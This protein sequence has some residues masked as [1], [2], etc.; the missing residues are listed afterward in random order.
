M[1][2]RTLNYKDNQIQ[3]LNL[4]E[5]K[6]TVKEEGYDGKPVMGMYHFDFIER[7]MEAVDKAKLKSTLDP[8]YSAQNRDKT[9]PGVTVIEKQREEF[10]EGSL[11]SFLMR[12]IF[13]RIIIS[14]LENDFTNTAV[15][16]SYNQ[17]GF[18]LA[19]GPNVK[20]CKNQCIMGVDKFMSTYS[21]DNKMPTPERMI[22]VLGEWLGN[23]KEI[24]E[25]ELETI[26]SLQTTIIPHHEVM[27]LVGDMT[28]KRIRRENSKEFPKEIINPLNQ[29][30]IG[31][32]TKSYMLEKQKEFD[33]NFS[34]WD[35][36]NFATQLYKPGLTDFPLL[37]SNNSAMSEYLMSRYN[38]N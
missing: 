10:G 16:L 13:A 19:F 1:K 30:Q 29:S 35:I 11:Q 7:A 8:I 36:Y 28:A 26:L 23:F 22:E 27:E 12:R 17:M 5:L 9:R 18:Q 6:T 25:K 2:T 3:E 20:I 15:A 38:L 32:F 34:A 31:T 4:E 21:H 37:L 24:R 33:K 14:N